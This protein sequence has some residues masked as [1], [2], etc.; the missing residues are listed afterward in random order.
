MKKKWVYESL[1]SCEQ[2]IFPPFLSRQKETQVLA[3]LHVV[4]L[5]DIT[6]R[7]TI[8]LRLVLGLQIMISAPLFSFHLLPFI[9]L[10]VVTFKSVLF[11]KLF[12]G[13]MFSCSSAHFVNL[14]IY[15]VTC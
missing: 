13:R 15:P 5:V 2:I 11:T 4:K 8:C 6:E 12:D 1:N 10:T 14:T 7:K 3:H 9:V